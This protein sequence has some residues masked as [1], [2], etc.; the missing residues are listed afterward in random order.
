MMR[1]SSVALKIMLSILLF[2]AVACREESPSLVPVTD[3]PAQQTPPCRIQYLQ[4]Y[5]GT[6]TSFEQI[7]YDS[8][9]VNRVN[10]FSL[11][12]V[13]LHFYYDS[14]LRYKYYSLT[15]PAGG[16]TTGKIHLVVEKLP[17]GRLSR[18][19]DPNAQYTQLF[20]HHPND[21]V[22]IS[23]NG[24][25]DAVSF[26]DARGNET[27]QRKTRISNGQLQ[28]E[29]KLM[30]YD[31]SVNPFGQL[32]YDYWLFLGQSRNN[33]QKVITKVNGTTVKE[34]RFELKYDNQGRLAS[35]TDT[36][37]NNFNVRI[38]NYYPC[39]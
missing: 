2:S 26:F 9:G 35:M 12:E 19:S 24:Q 36:L 10:L 5:S 23:V 14:P 1:K 25:P 22:Y 20:T 33:L 18:L 38:M 37:N 8:T 32:G 16:D 21:S 28:I 31:A 6:E 4:N 11:S 3:L 34:Q 13:G 17:N 39:P 27:Y 15:Y 7:F 29:E 30:T